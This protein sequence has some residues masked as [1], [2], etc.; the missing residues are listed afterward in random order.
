M[1][2]LH[3]FPPPTV[4][5]WMHDRCIIFDRPM[6]VYG[7]LPM[8]ITVSYQWLVAKTR[9]IAEPMPQRSGISSQPEGG[10]TIGYGRRNR[11]A[12][13]MRHFIPFTIYKWKESMYNGPWHRGIAIKHISPEQLPGNSP[14]RK[15]HALL[16]DSYIL[17]TTPTRGT[18]IRKHRH[19]NRWS[20][21]TN[22]NQSDYAW[23]MNDQPHKWK[24]T[25]SWLRVLE[26]RLERDGSARPLFNPIFWHAA[27]RFDSYW[28]VIYVGIAISVEG[29]PHLE[30]PVPSGMICSVASTW[31]N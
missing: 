16:E 21:K 7:W 26:T 14:S 25:P 5:S 20:P 19:F 18:P 12:C 9:S 1:Q 13:S 8:P 11:N 22:D 30:S 28:W 24:R 27:L 17:S 2:G 15:Y 6:I 10:H 3:E 31:F 4:T 29:R 23:S